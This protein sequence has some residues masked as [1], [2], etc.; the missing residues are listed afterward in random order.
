MVDRSGVPVER[1]AVH[2]YSFRGA[3]I[4]R[5]E[6]FG[7]RTEALDAVGLRE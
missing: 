3:R 2:V 4:E 1:G 6:I 5:V 7:S